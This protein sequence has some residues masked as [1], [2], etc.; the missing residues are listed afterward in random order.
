MNPVPDSDLY[1]ANGTGI[2]GDAGYSSSIASSVLSLV[3][4]GKRKARNEM[5]EEKRGKGKR[6]KRKRGKKKTRSQ[7]TVCIL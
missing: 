1:T 6:G 7:L 4:P 3:I 2:W 5:R